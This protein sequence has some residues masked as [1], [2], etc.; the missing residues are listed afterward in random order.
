MNQENTRAGFIDNKETV[1]LVENYV[2]SRLKK[3]DTQG[4]VL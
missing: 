2:F 1:L 3:R 4:G